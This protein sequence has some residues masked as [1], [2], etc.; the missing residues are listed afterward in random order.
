MPDGARVT[1]D[2]L[3]DAALPRPPRAPGLRIARR[4]SP[5]VAARCLAGLG[6]VALAGWYGGER[7]VYRVSLEGVV[8]SPVL[9]LHAPVDGRIVRSQARAGLALAQDTTLFRIEDRRLDTR[10]AAQL[11]AEADRIVA[12]LAAIDA[13]HGELAAM[14]RDLAMRVAAHRA[15]TMERLHRQIRELDAALDAARS[16]EQHAAI[17]AE[18]VEA[19]LRNEFA[20]RQRVDEARDNLRRARAEVARTTEQSERVR[21]E[22]AAAERGVLI[23]EGYGDVPYS[24]QRLD[25]IRLLRADLARQ[26]AN[27]AAQLAETKSRLAAEQSRL[28][29]VGAA[30]IAAPGGGLVTLVGVSEGS[31]V[32]R[33]DILA[34]IVDCR[35]AYIEAALPEK[36][37]D[38]LRPGDTA[39]VTLRGNS[40][41][42]HGTV[43]AVKGAGATTKIEAQ[44]AALER[45]TS[46]SMTVLLDLDGAELDRMSGSLCQAGRKATVVFSD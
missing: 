17:D 14:Q 44:A 35:R 40:T 23:G 10:L 1:A 22:L 3:I 18:R 27:L 37:Y 21:G 46:D 34:E 15:A 43:R 20:S 41:A 9:T 25:E 19:L 4:L 33:G 5:A 2:E 42:L 36:G 16:A 24:E 38:K 30:E 29:E 7:L 31:E 8:N 11:A 45:P 13:Q 26:S 32:A 28:A 6:V 12:Q 39:T